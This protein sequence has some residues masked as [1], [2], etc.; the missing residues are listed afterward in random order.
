[1]WHMTFG[2]GCVCI[3]FCKIF[4]CRSMDIERSVDAISVECNC[5]SPKENS[6]NKSLCKWLLI[7]VQIENLAANICAFAPNGYRII[8]SHH[9]R[10]RAPLFC[11]HGWKNT[12]AAREDR[13]A[14][15]HVS[16]QWQAKTD[17]CERDNVIERTAA[18]QH[19]VQTFTRCL[20]TEPN[21][22]CKKGFN[23]KNTFHGVFP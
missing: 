19:N 11:K 22:N 5:S 9:I 8:A 10:I 7:L 23:M 13:L 14:G 18:L 20:H 4:L 15:K 3:R 21:M 17:L 6:S 2:I 16:R 12:N 1:M